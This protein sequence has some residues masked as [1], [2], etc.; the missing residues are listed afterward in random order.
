MSRLTADFIDT[1][2]GA[3]GRVMADLTETSGGPLAGVSCMSRLTADF[4]DT[5]AGAAG[6]VMADLTETE[7]LCIPRTSVTR[8]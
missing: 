5:L 7:V 8:C 2:A 4:I 1:L 3:A 6:R